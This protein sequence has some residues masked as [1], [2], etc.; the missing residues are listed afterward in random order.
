MN[1]HILLTLAHSS[2]VAMTHFQLIPHRDDAAGQEAM[3]DAMSR[4]NAS[5]AKKERP[6]SKVGSTARNSGHSPKNRTED[7]N[8]KTSCSDV[9]DK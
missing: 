5:S 6:K 7:E 1:K 8:P 3:R 9:G 4:R 2:S